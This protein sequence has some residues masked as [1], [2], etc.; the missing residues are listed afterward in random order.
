L[1]Q[2]GALIQALGSRCRSWGE[3]LL[4]LAELKQRKPMGELPASV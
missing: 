1:K 2:A 4:E 3:A